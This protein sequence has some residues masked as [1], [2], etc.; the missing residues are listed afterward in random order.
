MILLSRAT[1]ATHQRFQAYTENSLDALVSHT[2]KLLFPNPLEFFLT[3][4]SDDLGHPCFPA[5]ELDHAEHAH[6]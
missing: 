4:F 1:L 5:E 2:Q 3:L 6:D